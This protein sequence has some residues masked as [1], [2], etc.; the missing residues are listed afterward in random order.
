[1]NIYV[2]IEVLRI[3]YL[4]S[5]LFGDMQDI[6]SV[7][8]GMKL[9]LFP[10]ISISSLCTESCPKTGTIGPFNNS[11]WSIC[12]LSGTVEV[13]QPVK[14]IPIFRELEGCL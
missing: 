8:L 2:F 13:T 7:T 11:L 10:Q 4:K 1:M 14:S 9:R 5:E 12:Y 3:E 6:W